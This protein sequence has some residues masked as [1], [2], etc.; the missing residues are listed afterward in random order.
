M[1][2]EKSLTSSRSGSTRRIPRPTP[3]NLRNLTRTISHQWHTANLTKSERCESTPEWLFGSYLFFQVSLAKDL[4]VRIHTNSLNR[5]RKA[6][7]ASIR[8][9]GPPMAIHIL[10]G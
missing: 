5:V 10:H 7:R 2:R 4:N 6:L 8:P 9:T 3:R 1:I